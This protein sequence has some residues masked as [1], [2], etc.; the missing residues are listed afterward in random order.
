MEYFRDYEYSL[1]YNVIYR[2]KSLYL[3][4]EKEYIC[5]HSKEDYDEYY[6]LKKCTSCNI[7]KNYYLVTHNSFGPALIRYSGNGYIEEIWMV[8]GCIHR[9]NEPAVIFYYCGDIIEQEWYNYDRLH[10]IDGPAVINEYGEFY[11]LWGDELS[12]EEYYK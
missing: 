9:N 1:K 6:L 4:I 8:K 2:G 5:F 10:R 7:D 12:K 11:Y 3:H